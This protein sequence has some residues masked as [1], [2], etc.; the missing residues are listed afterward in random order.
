MTTTVEPSAPASAIRPFTVQVPEADLD[1]LRALPVP[2]LGDRVRTT[3]PP[4][5]RPGG[6]TASPRPRRAAVRDILRHDK[7]ER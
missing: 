5:G 4:A 1:D 6:S 3:R 2:A 7:E